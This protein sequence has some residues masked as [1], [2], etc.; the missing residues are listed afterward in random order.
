MHLSSPLFLFSL[1]FSFIIRHY[2][3]TKQAP[4]HY[5]STFHPNLE[6][7]SPFFTPFSGFLSRY[8][9]SLAFVLLLTSK[10]LVIHLR[11]SS[12]FKLVFSFEGDDNSI[13]MELDV[14]VPPNG[15]IKL[16]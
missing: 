2:H 15:L 4:I 11:F 14:A 13:E 9:K 7:S 6:L 5:P 8:S 12:S 3:L 10:I 16:D 1:F